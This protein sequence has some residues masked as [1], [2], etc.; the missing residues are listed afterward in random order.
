[1]FEEI[2][3]FFVKRNNL[4]PALDSQENNAL[5]Y[6]QDSFVEPRTSTIVIANQ[7]GGCGK[8]TTAI[9]LS[10]ALAMKGFKVLIIDLDSQSHASLGLGI[11][12]DNLELS[13]YDVLVRNV[14]LERVVIPTYM[15]KLDIV[16]ALP[17]L[18]GAQ[19]EIA[20][21]L[22]R[23]GILRTAIHK[24]LNIGKKEY[25]YILI[26]CSP[27]L[28]LLT[29][30][31]LVAAQYVLIP[32]QTHYFSLE[33]MKELFATIKIVRERLNFQMQILGIL[34]TLFD[35]R[36]RMN[37]DFLEQIKDYFKDNVFNSLIR[38]NIKLAEASA[39]RKS[40]FDY[41]PDSNGAEDYASLSEEIIT[42]SK[43]NKILK[44]NGTKSKAL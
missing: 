10:A 8:T 25:D 41:A 1:V 24:M 20:D 12:L 29:I 19:L 32:L 9:N 7:K 37:K 15:S 6:S 11:D 42:L 44:D 17:M 13:I 40:I 43:P 26:D 16:P 38:M 23:E 35:S 28:N 39:N 33:G 30:N 34:P 22:G 4:N 2:K 21:L 31:G 14:E 36:T 18:S 3:S 27:S 5:A